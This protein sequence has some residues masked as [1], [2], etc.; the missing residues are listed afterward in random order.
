MAPPG[1]ILI[2]HETSN[3]RIT[4][5][6]HGQD[7]WYIVPALEHYRC[8]TVYIT[9][10]RLE[11]VVETVDFLPTEVPLPFPSSKELETQAAKQLTH[12]LLNPQPAGPFYQVGNK[13]M[14][15]IQRLSAI[16]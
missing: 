13:Q 6:S 14:L 8:Y 11:R 7:E 10:T 5:A 3:R 16:F 15:A 12:A 9:K 1:T 4:W 2:A